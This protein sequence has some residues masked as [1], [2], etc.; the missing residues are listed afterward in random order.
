MFNFFKNKVVS[1]NNKKKSTKIISK[2]HSIS[3]REFLTKWERNFVDSLKNKDPLTLTE[4]Q[5][6]K[7]DEIYI[8]KNRPKLRGHNVHAAIYDDSWEENS[9]PRFCD[10]YG[11]SYDDVHDFDR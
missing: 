6:N 5:L 2:I 7:L 8:K 9:D 1:W 3:K 4:K 10:K 11:V